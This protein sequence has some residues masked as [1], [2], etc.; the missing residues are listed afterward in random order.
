MAALTANQQAPVQVG[1]G[2]QQQHATAHRHPDTEMLFHTA[3]HP[4]ACILQLNFAHTL[5]SSF[6]IR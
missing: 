6:N 5:L 4:I 1:A 2:T 3:W